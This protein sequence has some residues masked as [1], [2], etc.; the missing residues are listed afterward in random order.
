MIIYNLAF[1]HYTKRT[2]IGYVWFQKSIKKKII[3]ENKFL[4][5]DY[6]MKN[7]KENPI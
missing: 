4:M 1:Y 3:K 6:N 7:I 2:F 5:C